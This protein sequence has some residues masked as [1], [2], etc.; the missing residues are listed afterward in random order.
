MHVCVCITS[1]CQFAPVDPQPK[2]EK[3]TE[4][5]PK[6][7][8]KIKAANGGKAPDAFLPMLHVNIKEDI[9]VAD[10]PHPIP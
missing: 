10:A 3:P 6:T 4:N 7:W 5:I 9:A 2:I 1:C 8:D